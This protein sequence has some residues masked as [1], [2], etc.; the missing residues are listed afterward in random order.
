MFREE[1]LQGLGKSRSSKS[2]PISRSNLARKSSKAALSQPSFGS[3][4][5]GK[6]NARYSKAGYASSTQKQAGPKDLVRKSQQAEKAG[7]K[8]AVRRKTTGGG[9]GNSLSIA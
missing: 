4:Q 3:L 2:K 1:S 6:A 9:M 7:A 5:A 8:P